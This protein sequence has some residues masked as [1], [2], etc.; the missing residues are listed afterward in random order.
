MSISLC[1]SFKFMDEDLGIPTCKKFD[2]KESVIRL[3]MFRNII[4]R[5]F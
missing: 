2:I 1:I 3:N 5:P 4:R